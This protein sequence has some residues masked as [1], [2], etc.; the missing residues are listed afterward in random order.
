MGPLR[1]TQAILVRWQPDGEVE[2]TGRKLCSLVVLEDIHCVVQS[3]ANLEDGDEG[4]LSS[5][6]SADWVAKCLLG[7]RW[8]SKTVWGGTRLS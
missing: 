8:S 3:S 5:E 6:S 2:G 7:R 4:E 1:L